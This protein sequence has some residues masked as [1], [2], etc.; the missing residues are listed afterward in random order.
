MVLRAGSIAELPSGDDLIDVGRVG[1][2][3]EAA[4]YGNLGVVAANKVAGSRKRPRV[5]YKRPMP[6]RT[7]DSAR[8]INWLLAGLPDASSYLEV[9][10]SFGYTF[11][12][13]KAPVRW[14]VDPNPR[15]DVH[16]LPPGVHVL[17][18]TSDEFFDRP[19]SRGSHFDVVFLDGLHTFRQ[20]YRDLI[21]A[22]RLCPDGIIVMDDIVPVDETSAIPDYDAALETSLC[23]GLTRPPGLW[24]GDVFR[25]ILSIHSYHPELA[26][27]TIEGPGNPQALIWKKQ[28]SA[29]VQSA[30]ESDL[31]SVVGIEYGDVFGQGIP[32]Y[33]LPTAEDVALRNALSGCLAA[34]SAPR[35]TE[36]PS[37]P[38]P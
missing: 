26:F 11:E 38:R 20:T 27:C 5:L 8:R 23:L 1:R 22:F 14:G 19:A 2:I 33:F 21:N 3:V 12:N 4:A 18:G 30:S 29:E 13:V 9:G 31:V 28:V 37:G 24:H 16:R 15:F 6:G 7:G 25:V 35:M 36:D 34:R 32:S 17:V 10:L